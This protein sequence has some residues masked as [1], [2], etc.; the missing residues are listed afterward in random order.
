MN[1]CFLPIHRFLLHLFFLLLPLNSCFFLPIYGISSPFVLAD[2]SIEHLCVFFQFTD[3]FSIFS[4]W[5]F[6]WTLLCFFQFTDFFSF[7]SCWSFL[8]LNSWG[9][10]QFLDFFSNFSCWWSFLPLNSFHILSISSSLILSC[11]FENLWICLEHRRIE[12]HFL[13]YSL[14]SLHFHFSTLIISL[15]TNCRKEQHVSLTRLIAIVA[16]MDVNCEYNYLLAT[17]CLL[18]V[19]ICSIRGGDWCSSE[20]FQVLYQPNWIRDVLLLLRGHTTRRRRRAA[21]LWFW[22]KSKTIWDSSV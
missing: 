16:G 3:F 15:I 2:P 1:S 21:Y 20:C 7:C 17:I 10:F 14:Y 8:P 18:N 22:H 12:D 13:L 11:H 19:W 4:C 6:H 9:F 5:S